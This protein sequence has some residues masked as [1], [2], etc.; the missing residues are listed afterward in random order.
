MN[1]VRFLLIIFGATVFL[2]AITAATAH[3]APAWAPFAYGAVAGLIGE[4]W[5]RSLKLESL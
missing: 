1:V 2:A 5:V 3:V 4:W